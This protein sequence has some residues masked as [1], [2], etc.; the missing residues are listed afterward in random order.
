MICKALPLLFFFFFS[1]SLS[2]SFNVCLIF[3]YECATH[4]LKLNVP[5]TRTISTV[6][7]ND[8]W[9]NGFAIRM[10]CLY[11]YA[12]ELRQAGKANGNAE[13]R[14][15]TGTREKRDRMW[16]KALNSLI[17]FFFF[18]H[19]MCVNL[20]YQKVYKNSIIG[21]S[22]LSVQTNTQKDRKTHI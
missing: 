17:S 8:S 22:Y 3:I 10:N 19:G 2:P 16:I 7:M 9:S 5:K 14:W 21:A 13:T 4:G 1:L 12:G 6:T 20:D 18:L 11:V 15:N